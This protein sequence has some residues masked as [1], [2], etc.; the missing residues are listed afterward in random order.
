MA[1]LIDLLPILML[2]RQVEL[3]TLRKTVSEHRIT[4][5]IKDEHKVKVKGSRCIPHDTQFVDTDDLIHEL[6]CSPRLLQIR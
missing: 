4:F 3:L 6:W 5:V 2:D 1:A